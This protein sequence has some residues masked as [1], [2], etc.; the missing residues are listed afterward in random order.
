M[1]PVLLPV[2]LEA[3]MLSL[4]SAFLF[5]FSCSRRAEGLEGTAL[6]GLVESFN[7]AFAERVYAW[8]N[9][10]ALAPVDR[11]VGQ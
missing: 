9:R 11:Y 2:W 7:R 1:A 10:A 3:M 5:F 4:L 6:T 8:R